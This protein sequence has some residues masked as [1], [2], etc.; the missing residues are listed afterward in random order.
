MGKHVQ[1][2]PVSRRT[3]VQAEQMEGSHESATTR[4]NRTSHIP[5]SQRSDSRTLRSEQDVREIEAPVPLAKNVRRSKKV[6]GV[7]P[8]LSDSRTTET[9]QR[10]KPYS[11]NR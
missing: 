3:I 2:V 4:R 5:V 7:M 1:K 11:T 10:T 9:K 8:H 6:R